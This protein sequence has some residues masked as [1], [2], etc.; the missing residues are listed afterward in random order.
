MLARRMDDAGVCDATTSLALIDLHQQQLSIFVDIIGIATYERMDVLMLRDHSLYEQRTN[1]LTFRKNCQEPIDKST[2]GKLGSRVRVPSRSF[3][4]IDAANVH[5]KHVLP[6]RACRQIKPWCQPPF[7]WN[8]WAPFG[9]TQLCV[10]VPKAPTRNHG[11][12]HPH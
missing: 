6:H 4:T 7:I 2:A 1:Q 10:G 12:T 3:K 11:A 8:L 9:Q 5:E